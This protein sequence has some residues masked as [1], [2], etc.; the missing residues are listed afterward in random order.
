MQCENFVLP[1]K[2]KNSTI[3]KT[4]YTCYTESLFLR[5]KKISRMLPRRL[6]KNQFNNFVKPYH[7]EL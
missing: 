1:W 2:L 5:Y 4:F 7:E 6:L 3:N